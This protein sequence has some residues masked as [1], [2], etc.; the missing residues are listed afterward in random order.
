[1]LILTRR[2][3]ETIWIKDE[4]SGSVT[5]IRINAV[6]HRQN[7]ASRVQ[8]GIQAPETVTV[9]RGELLNDEQRA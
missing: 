8:V 9:L 4:I 5:T 1:M 2:E 3:E 6:Q 7:G